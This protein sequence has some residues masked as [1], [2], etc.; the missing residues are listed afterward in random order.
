MRHLLLALPLVI[1]AAPAEAEAV[2]AG[3]LVIDTA[4]ASATIGR[5]STTAAYLTI[6]NQGGEE[7]RL[8][9]ASSPIAERA[10]LHISLEVGGMARMRPVTQVDLPTGETVAMTPGGGLH[11]MLEGLREPLREGATVP[12][13]LRFERAGDVQVE[14]EV[15]GLGARKQ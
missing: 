11:L 8:V 9:G 14:A 15:V 13:T 4:T 5:S 7:D 12:L 3:S 1:F 2:R 6:H 10:T